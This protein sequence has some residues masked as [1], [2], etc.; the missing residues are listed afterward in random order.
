MAA[1]KLLSYEGAMSRERFKQ[2]AALIVLDRMMEAFGHQVKARFDK[3]YPEALR[4]SLSQFEEIRGA[5]IGGLVE[6]IA[7]SVAAK[8]GSLPAEVEL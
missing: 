1:T 3:T 8:S 4:K 6:S 5:V 2:E 7:E